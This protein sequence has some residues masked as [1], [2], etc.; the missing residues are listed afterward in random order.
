MLEVIGFI[1]FWLILIVGIVVIPFGIAG[2]FIIVVA[3]FVYGLVTQFRTISL[4]F[5]LILLGI[6]ILM[7]IIEFFMG[8]A[9]AGKYGSS[10]WGMWGAIIGGLLGAIW[11]TPLFPLV[12]TVIGG[13]IGS[14]VGAAFF[15]FLRFQD[16]QRALRAG[17]GAFLGSIGG[18]LLKVLA[19]IIMVVMIGF[20]V[21]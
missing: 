8:A 12:G 11:G 15:E 3:A 13:I 17:W 6:A 1:F 4:P 14:L 5:V 19:G 10:A 9:M 18:R 2:T 21:F 16:W 7:E 20:R